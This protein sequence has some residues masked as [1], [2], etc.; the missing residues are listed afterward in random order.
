MK[1][2]LT[3]LFLVGVLFSLSTNGFAKDKVIEKS[4]SDSKNVSLMNIYL[5]LKIHFIR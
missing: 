5:M 2:N 1:N 4:N 3:K